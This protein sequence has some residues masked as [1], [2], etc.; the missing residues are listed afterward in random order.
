VAANRTRFTMDVRCERLNNK[1]VVQWI[2]LAW[3]GRAHPRNK[4]QSLSL[5]IT[6]GYLIVLGRSRH[7]RPEVL[8]ALGEV[9][10]SSAGEQTPPEAYSIQPMDKHTTRTSR[11]KQSGRISISAANDAEVAPG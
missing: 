6:C 5:H 10:G 11:N 1:S 9:R 3:T 8:V 4:I 7:V 2:Q